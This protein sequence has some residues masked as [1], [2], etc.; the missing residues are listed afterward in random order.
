MRTLLATLLLKGPCTN[1]LCSCALSLLPLSSNIMRL[2][3]LVFAQPSLLL[4]SILFSSLNLHSHCFISSCRTFPT[5][6][7]ALNHWDLVELE[8]NS[9]SNK[10]RP[11]PRLRL[12]WLARFC[13]KYSWV[14][15]SEHSASGPRM[16]S[17]SCCF[18]LKLSLCLILMFQSC[19]AVSLL[20]II[21]WQLHKN[22]DKKKGCGFQITLV[23]TFTRSS[24]CCQWIGITALSSTQIK[25]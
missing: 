12:S 19:F 9:I 5:A 2:H 15:S 10:S 17:S 6:T 1:N 21:G 7:S 4:Q 18:H 3:W 8:S 13:A 22:L 25:W 20:S 16:I 23:W 24:S 11:F 14:I